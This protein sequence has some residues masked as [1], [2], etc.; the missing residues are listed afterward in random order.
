M[1]MLSDQMMLYIGVGIIVLVL[2]WL[3]Y[4]RGYF[5]VIGKWFGKKNGVKEQ[6]KQDVTDVIDDK[7]KQV[8]ESK[9]QAKE[10]VDKQAEEEKQKVDDQKEQTKSEIDQQ[11]EVEKQKLELE[12]QQKHA[13]IETEHAKKEGGLNWSPHFTFNQY[14]HPSMPDPLSK[15]PHIYPRDRYFRI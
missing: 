15:K 7:K 11:A 3:G 14:G 12:K 6:Q 13:E 4:S 9:E 2:I 10:I 8:D 5:A 1:M